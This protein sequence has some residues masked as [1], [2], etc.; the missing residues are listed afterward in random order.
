MSSKPAS[1]R[2]RAPHRRA[3]HA[4]LL[5]FRADPLHDTADPSGRGAVRFIPD[6]W[7]L[8]EDGLTVDVLEAG[9]APGPDWSR[10]DRRGHLVCPGFI[11][12]H[13]HS[14]QLDVVASHGA[15]LLQWL[16]QYT[17]PNEMRFADPAFARAESEAF[18]DALLAHGTTTAVVFPTRHAC[19]VDALFEAAGRRDMCLIGG[20]VLMDR[21]GPEA[22]LDG[23]DHGETESRALIRRWHEHQR[24]HYAITPRFA[25]TSSDAQLALAGRLLAEADTLYMQT[26]VAET[27]EEVAWV[28]KLFPADRS[29][30]SVYDRHGLLGPRSVF[31]H[32]IWLDDQDHAMLVD[33]GG[34]VAF[35]PSSN[36]F[37]GSGLLNVARLDQ[38]GVPVSLASD[39]GGGTHLNMLRVMADAARVMAL[40]GQKLTAYRGLYL[41]TLGAA[42]TLALDGA[43]GSLAPGRH[44]DLTV[45]RWSTDAVSERRQ[46]RA[47][48]L[49]ERLFAL[50]MLGDTANVVATYVRGRCF[51][52]A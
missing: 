6:G 1:A 30:L 38:A 16:E 47:T 23:A 44:A 14:G 41:A 18:C 35:S 24:L 25:P 12:T 3:I 21:H 42:R 37:L 49:H 33:R 51:E 8:I 2:P 15:T 20:K 29:Y 32:G 43:I 46:R 7:L 31:A 40:T 4:D 26:H 9:Q 28:A 11:D 34:S 17:F 22:L 27:E 13:V 19:S 5:D 10:D 36:M 48:S 45:L 39:V 52:R 50:M